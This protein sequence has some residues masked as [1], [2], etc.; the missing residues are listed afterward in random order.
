MVLDV[1][2]GDVEATTQSITP[3]LLET[4]LAAALERPTYLDKYYALQPG[5]ANGAKR[6]VVVLPGQHREE[7]DPDWLD[8]IGAT[9]SLVWRGLPMDEATMESFEYAWPG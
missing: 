1:S 8:A 9:A 7:F 4:L 2:A 3:Q 5:R 6:L